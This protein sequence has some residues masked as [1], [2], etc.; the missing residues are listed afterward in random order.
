MRADYGSHVG[1]RDATERHAFHRT[2]DLTGLS[3]IER[4]KGSMR[5]SRLSQKSQRFHE[6]TFS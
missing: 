5:V 3:S 2:S 1:G 4:L 6:L